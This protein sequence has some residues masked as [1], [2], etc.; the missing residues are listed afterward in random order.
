MAQIAVIGLSSFGY[1][2]ARRL[3]ELGSEVV[4]IDNDREQIDKIKNFASK[5]VIADATDRKALERLELEE[6]D[7]V[8]I[9]LGESLESSILAAF[10]LKEMGVNKI[11]VKALSEDHARILEMIGVSQIVFPERESGYRL[12]TSLNR[13]EVLDWIPLGKDMSILEISPFKEMVGKT[14]RELDFRNRYHCQIVAIRI[15]KTREELVLPD[16]EFKIEVQ[17]LLVLMGQNTDLEELQ[18]RAPSK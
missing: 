7:A 11:V 1:Y 13:P 12:A 8:V 17:H 2:L 18:R 3:C 14:I 6:M 15:S 9:S 16:P 5:A 10:Y 4:A